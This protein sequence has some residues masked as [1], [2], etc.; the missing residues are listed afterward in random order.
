MGLPADGICRSAGFNFIEILDIR[1]KYMMDLTS[2][3][4]LPLITPWEW[5]DTE[6]NTLAQ[7]V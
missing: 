1:G 5:Y 6:S 3:I 7:V 4:T 2:F